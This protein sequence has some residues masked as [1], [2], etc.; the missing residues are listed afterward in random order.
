MISRFLDFD[1][2]SGIEQTIHYDADTDT[3]IIENRYPDLDATM[4]ACA[5]LR[6]RPEYTRD[7]MKTEWLHLAHIPMALIDH[8]MHER[9][10]NVFDKNDE[11]KVL[12]LLHDEFSRFKTTDMKHLKR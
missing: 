2:F 10:I 3:S 12:S 7:G 5:E 1:P 9:H 11:K 4:D 6:N 8:L